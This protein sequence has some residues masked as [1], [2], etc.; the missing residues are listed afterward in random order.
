MNCEVETTTHNWML[1][2][3]SDKKKKKTYEGTE[4]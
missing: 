2:T 3:L 4:F 1:V